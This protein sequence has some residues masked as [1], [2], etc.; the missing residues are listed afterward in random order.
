MARV[1][2]LY[3]LSHC[4]LGL[5]MTSEWDVV[6]YGTTYLEAQIMAQEVHF[7]CIV[8]HDWPFKFKKIYIYREKVGFTKACLWVVRCSTKPLL[9]KK[10]VFKKSLR[11]VC[12]VHV[13]D[14]PI[15]IHGTF[16]DDHS[17]SFSQRTVC[18]TQSHFKDTQCGTSNNWELSSGAHC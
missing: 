7:S 15:L 17:N 14:Q 8:V 1:A 18:S 11:N 4:L 10:E 5:I 12:V 3:L 2:L 6:M 13:S 16:C 9:R